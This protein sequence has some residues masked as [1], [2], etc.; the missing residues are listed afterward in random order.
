MSYYLTK[1]GA[2]SGV[3]QSRFHFNRNQ[4]L[5]YVE[6][7]PDE[8]R[9]KVSVLRDLEKNNNDFVVCYIT[10]TGSEWLTTAD[11]FVFHRKRYIFAQGYGINTNK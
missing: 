4:A 5:E 8:Y 6:E 9:T 1:D 11:G 10:E 2:G 7:L 3:F